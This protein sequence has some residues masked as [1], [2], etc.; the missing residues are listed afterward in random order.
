MNASVEL[1]RVLDEAIKSSLQDSRDSY[2][3]GLLY[4][5][6][7]VFIG[8]V[9]E[10]AEELHFPRPQWDITRGRYRVIDWGKRVAWFGWVLIVV[11]IAGECICE[12][13]R[14]LLKNRGSRTP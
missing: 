7:V 11:G 10:Q 2:F 14:N 3:Y 9:L 6:G 5:T 4:A 8:V 12:G 1:L 13:P